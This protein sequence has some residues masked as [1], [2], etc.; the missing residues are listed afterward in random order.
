MPV[1]DTGRVGGKLL[2]IVTTRDWDFVADLHT[3]LSEVMTSDVQTAEFGAGRCAW[4]VG[5][6]SFLCS[7]QQRQRASGAACC[8]DAVPT[9]VY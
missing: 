4:P 8:W 7:V 5:L 2:G 3:P 6:A 9:H 1:A